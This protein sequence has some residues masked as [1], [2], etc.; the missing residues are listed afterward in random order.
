M[1]WTSAFP[2]PFPER[3]FCGLH[4]VTSFST[5]RWRQN[6]VA[7]F[8]TSSTSLADHHIYTQ[9]L[10]MDTSPQASQRSTQGQMLQSSDTQLKSADTSFPFE[11]LPTELQLTIL[12][13]TMPQQGLRAFSSPLRMHDPAYE[14]ARQARLEELQHEDITP[15]GV[16]RTNRWISAQ[17]LHI[18]HREVSVHIN[19]TT[20]TINCFGEEYCG[21]FPC[22][23]SPRQSHILGSVS[24]VQINLGGWLSATETDFGIFQTDTERSYKLLKESLR[25]ICDAMTNN[26]NLQRLTI[27]L[28]CHCC[29]MNIAQTDTQLL[30]YTLIYLTPLRRLRVAHTV[31]L[32]PTAGFGSSPEVVVCRQP[33]CSRLADTIQ[34]QFSQLSGEGLTSREKKWKQIKAIANFEPNPNCVEMAVQT[35]WEQLEEGNHEDFEK[36]VDYTLSRLQRAYQRRV[37]REAR[38]QTGKPKS[39]AVRQWWGGWRQERYHTS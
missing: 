1:A 33:A 13:L 4:S 20:R 8:F 22:Q 5:T 27:T 9:L 21:R 23:V 11:K 16:F 31:D 29:L 35:F 30:A 19:L 7:H 28:P 17:A 6:L 36:I 34:T 37:R 14:S 25:Q 39:K 10:A 2:A 18:F 12:R 3:K 26:Q 38:P 32:L 15:T 24:N